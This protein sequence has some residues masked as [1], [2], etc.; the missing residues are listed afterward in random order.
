MCIT[1]RKRCSE[2]FACPD[3]HHPND[4]D[5]GVLLRL[6]LGQSLGSVKVRCFRDQHLEKD[7]KIFKRKHN[8]KEGEI[9]LLCRQSSRGLRSK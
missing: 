3:S 9:K 7:R 4:P 8:C 5:A 1:M 6:I 2:G